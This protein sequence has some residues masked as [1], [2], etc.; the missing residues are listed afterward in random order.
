MLVAYCLELCI[1]VRLLR[2]SERVIASKEHSPDT[3]RQHAV[4]FVATVLID[5]IFVHVVGR[6]SCGELYLLRHGKCTPA[7]MVQVHQPGALRGVTGTYYAF[8]NCSS[9]QSS[10]AASMSSTVS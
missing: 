5:T 1:W 10:T 2:F 9:A 7:L 8:C 6:T 3:P 4:A